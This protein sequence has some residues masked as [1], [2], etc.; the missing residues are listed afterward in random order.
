MI[1]EEVVLRI[2]A[3][4]VSAD[5]LLAGRLFLQVLRVARLQLA[6]GSAVVAAAADELPHERPEVMWDAAALPDELL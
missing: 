2:R 1:L 4:D 6:V 3:C 5:G